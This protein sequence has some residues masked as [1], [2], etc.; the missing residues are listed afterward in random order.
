MPCRQQFAECL[1][2]LRHVLEMQS[3]RRLVEQEEFTVM[4]RARDDRAGFGEVSREL[5]ALRLATRE[6][7]DR[8]AE[9]Y[10]L[11]ADVREGS[12][13]GSHFARVLEELER[14]RD[15]HFQ[16]VGDAR[17]ASVGAFA[18]DVEHF[19]PVAAAVA[20]GATQVHVREE[21]HLDVL[22]AVAAAGRAT[23]VTGVEAEGARRVLALLGGRLGGEQV[24]DRVERADIAGG[25]RA[26]RAT[27]RTLVHHHDVVDELRAAQARELSGGLGGFAA[28]FQERRVENILHEGGL[29]GP[30]DAGYAH[31]ALQRD[32]DIDVLQVVLACAGELQ[33]PVGAGFRDDFLYAAVGRGRLFGR[34]GGCGLGWCR[35]YCLASAQIFARQGA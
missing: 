31:E 16:H 2:Q 1:Q 6:G 25:I 10:I 18:L 23:A 34:F 14:F 9:F 17:A 22:K 15:R 33:P 12:E 29:S 5:Q 21:L 13:P 19:V 24:A 32:A 30:G 3:R 11:E 27:D 28:I 35:C 4:G 20:I 7:G 26:G 8:L